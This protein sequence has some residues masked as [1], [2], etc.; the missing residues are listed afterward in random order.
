MQTTRPGSRASS[1]R[2]R[3]IIVFSVGG[4][5]LA[6]RAE[7]VESVFPWS[8]SVPVPSQTPFVNAVI[9]RDQAVLPVF[10]LASRLKVGEPASTSLCLVAKHQDGPL[11]IRIDSEVPSLHMVD[12]STLQLR[13]DPDQDLLGTYHNEAGVIPVLSLAKLGMR[14]KS[15]TRAESQR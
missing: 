7:E 2:S 1:Q 3:G 8:H 9:R 15:D 5:Q 6:A 13:H 11:A 14:G 4:K 10:D 12:M